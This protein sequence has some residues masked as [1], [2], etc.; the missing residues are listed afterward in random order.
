MYCK[1]GCLRYARKVFDETP[2]RDVVFRTN[3]ISGYSNLGR[4][5]ESRVLFERMGMEGVKGNEFTW[6]ALIAG[7]ARVGDCDEAFKMVKGVELFREM[8]VAGVKPNPVT[9]MCLLHALVSALLDMYSSCGHGGMVNK[10]FTFFKSMRESQRVEIREEH[11][12]C[13]IDMLC[14]SGKIEEAY[15]LVHEPDL[16]KKVAAALMKM[17][18]NKPGGFVT[19]YNIYAAEGEWAK[20]EILREVMKVQEKLPGTNCILNEMRQRVEDLV[21]ET[22]RQRQRAAEVGLDL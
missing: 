19:L 4:V 8:L 1:C 21:E 15:D 13:V 11:Y 22:S 6:N 10:G 18:T 20:V 5:Q 12:G 14:R 7:Y 3:M 17:K 9:I 16:A 2:E